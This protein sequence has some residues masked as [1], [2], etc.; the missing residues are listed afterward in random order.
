MSARRESDIRQAQKLKQ[1]LID[2]NNVKLKANLANGKLLRNISQL[3]RLDI[4][5]KGL[6]ERAKVFD[7]SAQAI[8]RRESARNTLSQ[9]LLP[10]LAVAAIG[11]GIY[12]VKKLFD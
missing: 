12:R 3:R 5:S 8:S 4:L 2:I 10:A 6:S 1:A 11:Y 9:S 7:K